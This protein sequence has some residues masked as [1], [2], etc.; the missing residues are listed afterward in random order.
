MKVTQVDKDVQALMD[1]L[2]DFGAHLSKRGVSL[3]GR[4]KI[5][6]PCGTEISLRGSSQYAQ[7]FR[8]GYKS[9]EA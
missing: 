5:V 9:K 4:T 1:K 2:F 8:A 3:R 6:M 7:S